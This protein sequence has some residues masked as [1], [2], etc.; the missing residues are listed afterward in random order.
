M[1]TIN[2]FSPFDGAHLGQVAASNAA[3][4]ELALSTAYAPYRDR[5]GWLPK[6]RRIEIITRAAEII[7][8]RR[9]QIARQAAHEGGKPLKESLIEV[10]RGIDGLRVCIEELRQ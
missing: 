7:T 3:D 10:D 9:P 1:T 6:Q 4:I 8:Q 2:V 5:R